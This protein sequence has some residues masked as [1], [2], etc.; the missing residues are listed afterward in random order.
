MMYS[1]KICKNMC[2]PSVRRIVLGNTLVNVNMCSKCMKSLTNVTYN[3]TCG[4]CSNKLDLK[5]CCIGYNEYK[6]CP[7]CCN[8]FK[9]IIKAT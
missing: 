8:W 5:R 4:Y 2:A 7:S 3:H 6:I 9:T 1:C